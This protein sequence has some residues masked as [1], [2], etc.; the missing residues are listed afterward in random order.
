MATNKP[1]VGVTLEQHRYDLL[2]R[3][4]ALQGV[5]MSHL[6]ADLLET[7]SEPLERV[8][9]MLEAAKR[10][11]QEVKDGLKAAAIKSEAQFMPLAAAAIDQ[12]D[13]FLA[14]ASGAL[15]VDGKRSAAAPSVPDPRSVTRGSTPPSSPIADQ[16]KKP[17]KPNSG[18]ASLEKRG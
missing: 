17:R 6:I 13:M 2:K 3:L 11:P 4:A 12:L 18:K 7:V 10:A 16:P 9:V 1:R 5:S 15:G 14:E 8:A